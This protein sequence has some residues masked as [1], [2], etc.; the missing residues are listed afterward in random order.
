MIPD[1]I[2]ALYVETLA[3][4]TY[5]DKRKQFASIEPR[6]PWAELS[7]D[8]RRPWLDQ[9]TDYVDALA[10]AGLLP[11]YTDYRWMYEPDG[12]P[13]GCRETQLLTEWK[14]APAE[15]TGCGSTERRCARASREGAI[16]CCPDCRHPL[17]AV[18]E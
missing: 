5:E 7:A 18:S 15:C 8:D 14:E 16:K 13:I 12:T 4:V 3:R 10:E 6:Q 1:E 9:E 17:E 2:R 11:I